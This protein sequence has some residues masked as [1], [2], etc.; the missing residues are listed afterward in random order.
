MSYHLRQGLRARWQRWLDGLR[1]TAALADGYRPVP[2]LHDY[3][4]AR[5]R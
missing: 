5:R 2:E 1:A 3:P 4:V